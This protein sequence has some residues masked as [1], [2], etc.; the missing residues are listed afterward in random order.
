MLDPRT[1]FLSLSSGSNIG[2]HEGL[3]GG[4][5]WYDVNYQL[6]AGLSVES[7]RES[8]VG[9]D[10]IGG[11]RSFIGSL[12]RT[13]NIPLF[14]FAMAVFRLYICQASRVIQC[15]GWGLVV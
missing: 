15:E 8:L 11:E 13:S 4:S 3:T 14:V 7:S 2:L 6:T 9:G 12:H 10:T 1:C 5:Y